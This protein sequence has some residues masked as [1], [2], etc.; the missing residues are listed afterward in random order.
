MDYLLKNVD[1]LQAMKK[2][3]I[4]A[5]D[6]PPY[7]SVGGLR[8]YSWYKYFHEFDIYPIVITR[9]WSNKNGNYLDYIAAGET[10][11]E[12]I[13]SAEHG[14][15]IRAPYKP[16][17][18]NRI[19]LKYGD[20]KYKFLRK[21]I[22]AYYEFAQFIFLTGPKSKIYSAANNYLEKNSVDAIIATGD[23]F[24][25]FS[26]ASKLSEKYKTP[27]IADYRDIWSQNKHIQNKFLLKKWHSF[28]ENKIVKTS[29]NITTV[30]D[31]LQVKISELIK[32]KSFL[33]L[34]NG[35]DP[36]LVE[37]VKSIKQQNDCLSIAFVGSI[38]DWQPLRSF[39]SVM[40]KF[41]KSNKEI[42][43]RINF[44][45]INLYGVTFNGGL[46]EIIKS[47]YPDLSKYI[48]IHKKISNGQLLE[49][50]AK[51]NVMLLFNYYSYMGT[52]IF[53]YIGLERII[54]FCYTDDIE[55]NKLKAKYYDIDDVDNI[56]SHLQED[57]IKATNSGY[58][59]KDSS[60]LLDKLEE[61][62]IEFTQ[63]GII[64]CNTINSE[65]YSR[66]HQVEQLASLI[67]AISV[68][69]N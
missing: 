9:Q 34:P 53:D 42:K 41:I 30:S 3:L 32:E 52:K 55:A 13:E 27:W 26:Y 43:I 21:I 49:E 44:Y 7:V 60:Q 6:F 45:G 8:P 47:E 31:F 37:N 46:D 54:L 20:N 48:Q 4:L 12:I 56:S 67:K 64:K 35:Y 62:Y 66:K 59:I 28:F 15:I 1:L 2:I 69:K 11:K 40:S 65:M 5:Y 51:Q 25:L 57:L 61:L 33:I 36:E 16:N 50:L 22:S 63:T 38:Y 18:A 68:Q 19:M 10:N 29:A 14:T 17:F 24:I 23:P 39:L 58:L